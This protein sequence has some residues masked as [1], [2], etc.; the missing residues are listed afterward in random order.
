MIK[1][2]SK[3]VFKLVFQSTWL[4]PY[5]K[6][7][8]IIKGRYERKKVSKRSISTNKIKEIKKAFQTIHIENIVEL[9]VTRLQ[10][11]IDLKG[12]RTGF[13]LFN[14]LFIYLS[15]KYKNKKRILIFCGQMIIIFID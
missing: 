13:L 12:D 11:C 5:W 3:G 4:K 6:H 8:G 9:F 10:R 7:L 14:E 1:K 15:L 2:Q